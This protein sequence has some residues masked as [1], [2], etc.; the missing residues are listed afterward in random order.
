MLQPE[1][2]ERLSR[3]GKGTPAG[4]LYRRYWLPVAAATEL[5][6]NPVKPVRILGEDLVLF[7][8]EAGELGLVT[9]KCPHRGASLAY[10]FP[11]GPG[12]RCAYHGWLFDGTGSCLEQPNQE[13]ASPRLRERASITGYP[14]RELAGLIFAYLGEGPTPALPLLDLFTLEEN[15]TQFRDIGSAIIPC[16][17]LQIMENSFD[18]THVEWLHGKY[19]NYTLERAGEEP[20]ELAGHHIKI[21]FDL[22]D[23]GIIKRRLREGQTEESEDWRTG[24]PVYFPHILKVGGYGLQSLQIRVP[25]DDTNTLHF[26]YCWFDVEEKFSHLVQ[27]VR[28]LPD[29]YDV[30]LQNDDGT[31]RM[32]TID[33]QDAM[34]WVTQGPIAS[35][36]D[37]NLSSSDQGIALFRTLLRKQLDSN[38]AGE[39]VMNVYD[40]ATEGDVI[41]LPMERKELGF[42]GASKG[43]PVSAF[44][45]TQSLYSPRL[46]ALSKLIDAE[47]EQA[48]RVPS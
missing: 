33:S 36:H 46:T 27:Q 44:L 26:W 37:E 29:I 48:S 13:P 40:P 7:R 22:V 34:V 47:A 39:P 4:E 35:R 15:D 41:E 43:N 18:P 42:G 11:D 28:Q 8:S 14:V 31:F 24:H 9:R 32:D 6:E 19:F 21:G 10:G 1:L 2:N 45:R 30:K 17:W 12:L 38:E 23:Y 25:V 3:V 5:D 20:T 16:N